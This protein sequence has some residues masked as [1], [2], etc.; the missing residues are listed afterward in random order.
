MI[1][2]SSLHAVSCSMYMEYVSSA[3]T[4][5][6]ERS[7]RRFGDTSARFAIWYL[8]TNPTHLPGSYRSRSDIVDVRRNPHIPLEYAPVGRF[9]HFKFILVSGGHHDAFVGDRVAIDRECT[10][11]LSYS[12]LTPLE[13]AANQHTSALGASFFHHLCGAQL[14]L[15][16]PSGSVYLCWQTVSRVGHIPRMPIDSSVTL[17]SRWK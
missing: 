8:R 5:W 4:T 3:R 12:S 10:H 6:V 1:N 7:T 9:I 2:N 14:L 11:T 15:L 17:F 16:P 13:T